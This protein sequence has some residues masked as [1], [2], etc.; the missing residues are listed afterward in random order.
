MINYFVITLFYFLAIFVEN[1]ISSKSNSHKYVTVAFD[2]DVLEYEISN[3]PLHTEIVKNFEKFSKPIPSHSAH[4]TLREYENIVEESRDEE[5][6]QNSNH[7]FKKVLPTGKLTNEDGLVS[8]ILRTTRTI[9]IPSVQT[10]IYVHPMRHDAHTSS[11]TSTQTTQSMKTNMSLKEI[12][13]TEKEKILKNKVNY[14]G[15][16]KNPIGYEREV[17]FTNNSKKNEHDIS[18]RLGISIKSDYLDQIT[19]QR[20]NLLSINDSEEQQKSSA[21]NIEHHRL[22]NQYNL[23]LPISTLTSTTGKDYTLSQYSLF[24][25]TTQNLAT[26][27][28]LP[29]KTMKIQLFFP[30]TS[31]DDY[32]TKAETF[33]STP[34]YSPTKSE[35]IL[36]RKVQSH[37]TTSD[38]ENEVKKYNVYVPIKFIHSSTTF[39]PQLNELDESPTSTAKED[40]RLVDSDEDTVRRKLLTKDTPG[41]LS[42]RRSWWGW[43]G[44]PEKK[45]VDCIIT[46][47][48]L[49]YFIW[50]LIF[51]LL[52]MRFNYREGS[53]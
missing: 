49:N 45:Y 42:G 14:N 1:T 48:K 22:S 25:T 35:D 43:G 10:E 46:E 37:P 20:P 29:Y 47:V 50:S 4:T 26:T 39:W 27:T 28:E 5:N 8:K 3:K 18:T 51:V 12:D 17:Y 44:E 52:F 40:S 9:N 24:P 33:L 21:S 7:V 30:E 53:V 36:G 32:D 23:N 2:D 16:V 13:T 11:S 19:T 15:M 6:R 34:R 41:P 38:E 31:T